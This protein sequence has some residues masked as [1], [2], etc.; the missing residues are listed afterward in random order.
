MKF[1][2]SISTCPN[3]LFIFYGLLE[4]KI[5][6]YNINFNFIFNDIT[7]INNQILKTEYLDIAKISYLTYYYVLNKYIALKSG[8]ALGFG[9]GPLLVGKDNFSFDKKDILIG[10]PGK[11]TT[12]NFLLKFKFSTIFKTKEIL[13]SEIENNI[14]NE[15]V[16]LGLL[17]HESRFNYLDKN[18]VKII[19][20]G[21]FWT[22]KTNYPIPLGCIC[23]KKSINNKLKY[24]INNMINDSLQYSYKHYGKVLKYIQTKSS[25][26]NINI[27][28]QYIKLYVSKNYISNNDIKYNAVCKMFN[29]LN[30]TLINTKFCYSNLFFTNENYQS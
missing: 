4:N 8:S 7:T 18:L 27:I 20:L 15:N 30:K 13:Y 12:A 17:I 19:D 29:I 23:I 24:I 14:I 2:I 21:Q 22:Q 5:K 16:D 25:I 28:D 11:Y 1:N 6:H 9:Y 26:N 10:I 3:D